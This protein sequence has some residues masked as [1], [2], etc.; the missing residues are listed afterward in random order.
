[1]PIRLPDLTD[2]NVNGRAD[3]ALRAIESASLPSRDA[4][5]EFLLEGGDLLLLWKKDVLSSPFSKQLDFGLDAIVVAPDWKIQL[6]PKLYATSWL[7][8]EEGRRHNT[9]S[10][11]TQR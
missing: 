8:L 3:E 1:M 4:S 2:E 9:N 11:T 10:C 7:F 6:E 5:R